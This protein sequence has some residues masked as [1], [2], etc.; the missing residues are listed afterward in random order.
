MA[1]RKNPGAPGSLARKVIL[2][3]G[4]KPEAFATAAPASTRPLSSDIQDAMNCLHQARFDDAAAH[5]DRA[6]ERLPKNPMVLLATVQVYMLRMHAKGFD[7]ESAAQ[8]RRCLA[9]VDRQIP[10]E[11]RIF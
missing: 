7:A 1:A 11:N 6:R 10:G 2:D 9:E 3:A 8:V 4:L 5:I